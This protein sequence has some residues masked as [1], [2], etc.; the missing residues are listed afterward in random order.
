MERLGRVR[1]FGFD[2]NDLRRPVDR[3]QRAV[4][5]GAAVLFAGLAPPVSA[6]IAAHAYQAGV[7]AERQ[8][9]ANHRVDARVTRTQ[10]QDGAGVRHAYAELV[11]TSPDGRPH[12]AVV[13]AD[14]SVRPGMS[15]RIW[16]DAS[17]ALARAPST[18][19]ET[20]ATSAVSG[21]MAAGAVGLPLL[22][23]YLFTRRRCD[24]RRDALWDESWS[25]L[26]RN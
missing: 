21:G 1:R 6:V 24:R 14:K 18:H 2:R 15:H 22:A 23:V 26:A 11:W 7:A 4:G 17:G 3:R 10:P 12:T 20:I 5:A 19:A 13:A 16:V 8:Q 9:S 25:S